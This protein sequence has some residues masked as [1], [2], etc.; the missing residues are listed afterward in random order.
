MTMF[1]N[2]GFSIGNGLN[3]RYN[4]IAGFGSPAD[5][6]N[7]AAFNNNQDFSSD[8]MFNKELYNMPAA[9]GA[10]TR[11]FFGKNFMNKD[12]SMNFGNIG[13]S[14]NSLGNIF[15]AYMALQQFGMNKD[16][17]RLQ[18]QINR[19]NHANSIAIAQQD[20]DDRNR[21]RMLDNYHSDAAAAALGLPAPVA[22]PVLQ[23]SLNN[24][25]KNSGGNPGNNPGNVT[26][27]TPVKNPRD[28]T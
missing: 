23:N 24:S 16:D 1:N 2:N 18:Q 13:S 21:R 17:F 6:F 11:G 26:V 8:G 10:D 9:Q 22:A 14:I 12:G 3:N 20:I 15:G 25:G 28:Y 19:D 7:L 27:T 5:A 4:G